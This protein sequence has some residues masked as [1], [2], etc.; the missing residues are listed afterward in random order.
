M[1][2]RLELQG[3]KSFNK[4]IS[5]P[6][7]K[8]FTVIVGPNGSGK[9][10]ILDAICF[11]LGRTSARSLRA[12]RMTHLIYNGGKKSK[13]A[14]ALEVSLV[15]DNE[16]R[17]LPFDSDEVVVTRRLTRS[18]TMTY[19]L[20]T[21]RTTRGQLTDSLSSDLYVE[22]G[23]NI[24]LQGDVTNL[25]EMDPIERRQVLDELCGIAEYDFKKEKAL[26]NLKEVEGRI[27]ELVIMLSERKKHMDELKKEKEAAESYQKLK[28]EQTYS[29][30]R[31]AF[32]KLKSAEDDESKFLEKIKTE[33]GEHKQLDIEYKHINS[34]LEEKEKAQEKIDKKLIQG[35]GGDHIVVKGEI[36]RIRSTIS[37]S[38]SK[39]ES[40][41]SEI[42]RIDVMVSN[43]QSTSGGN[44]GG[45]LVEALKEEKI[46]GIFGTVGELVRF[47]SRYQTAIKTAMGARA[48]F[49]IVNNESTAITCVEYLKKNKL[50]RA[51]F[52]PISKIRGPTTQSTKALNILGL[53]INLVDFDNK[54]LDI[55]KYVFG[56][57]HIVKDLKS[58]KGF[59][60]KIRMVSIDGD[61]AE[62][63]GAITGGYRK[64]GGSKAGDAT[65]FIKNRDML[66]DKIEQLQLEIEDLKAKRSE[67]EQKDMDMSKDNE[68]LQKQRTVVLEEIEKLKNKREGISA[69]RDSIQR[70]ISDLRIEKARV[71]AKLTDLR[72][73]MKKFED[74]K[75]LKVGK[76]EDIERRLI[77]INQEMIALEPVNMKAIELYD[78]SIGEFRTFEEKFKHLQEERTS[79][80]GFIDEIEEKKK[81]VF[82]EVYNK[83]A[84][85]F[86]NI[87]PKLSP[88]GEADLQLELPD[89]PLNGGMRIE[90]RPAGKKL[91]SLDSMS[92]GEKTITALSFIFALQ[93]FKPAPFYVLDEVDAALDPHNSMRFVDLLQ[94]TITDAQLLVISHNPSIIKRADRVFG[95]SMTEIG[96]SKI[97]GMELGKDGK[98]KE[99]A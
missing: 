53:A 25:I 79:V 45:R 1:I 16:D 8:G 87:F 28:D 58:T 92:G 94:E 51:T 82:M 50:G 12:E 38:E 66:L 48:N 27:K 96:E 23:H 9:S 6:I 35:G 73:N 4:R 69:E 64:K 98:L 2:K 84:A 29:E 15:I 75:D 76:V 24:I 80:L 77:K 56:S 74:V 52:L 21:E 89:N 78:Q 55:Y 59:I 68:N 19:K 11:V 54:F 62:K 5:I 18:G 7:S 85:E 90:A 31:L 13:P 32:S 95:V 70:K 40:N 14:P 43:I 99:T 65:E 88:R 93:R 30:S 22:S 26:K 44:T 34:Q 39:I 20:N 10:N 97:I 41:R 63:S 60:G 72:I 47:D 36:E 42:G 17:K 67:F 37:I 83:V 46:E 91:L 49:I 33:E 57:T 3:F 86:K 81:D 61:L 71:D